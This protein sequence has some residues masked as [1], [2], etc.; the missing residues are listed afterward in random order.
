[1][2]LEQRL[3]ILLAEIVDS[4]LLDPATSDPHE[5]ASFYGRSPADKM[6]TIETNQVGEQLID[7]LSAML[8][9]EL[10]ALYNLRYRRSPGRGCHHNC[11]CGFGQGSIPTRC[12]CPHRPADRTAPQR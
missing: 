2:V 11:R 4:G 10:I 12:A 5:V 3:A 7:Q 8:H 1:M 9:A 6:L